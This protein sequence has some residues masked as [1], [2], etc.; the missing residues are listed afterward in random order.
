ME[1]TK[2]DMIAINQQFSDG[3]FENES[4]LD[5]ALEQQKHNIAWS[6]KAAHMIRA[7]L[8]DHVFSDG[9]KRTACFILIYLTELNGYK[10]EQKSSL[11][12][13]KRSVLKNVTSIRKIQ[14][15][16]ENAVTKED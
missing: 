3:Y 7:V 12:I 4:S 5:F 14:Y 6:K 11:G 16:I 1:L 8:I 10:I 9:N 13:I 15:M 2:K